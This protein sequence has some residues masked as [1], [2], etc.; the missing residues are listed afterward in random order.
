MSE[1][2]SRTATADISL[3]ARMNTIGPSS[4]PPPVVD[5]TSSRP[6]RSSSRDSGN[7]SRSSSR[8]HSRRSR[9][10]GSRSRGRHRRS[11]H[12]RQ[13]HRSCR[14]YFRHKERNFAAAT[15][16]MIAIVLLCIALVP[17]WIY[18]KGGGCEI[19]HQGSLH[20]LSTTQFFYGGHFYHSH[21]YTKPGDS[22]YHFGSSSNDI[23]VNCVTYTT[24]LLFKAC[25]AFTLIAV[26]CS[27]LSFILNL[28]GPE[29]HLLKVLRRNAIFNILT[30]ALCVSVNLFCY[31][32]TKSVETLQNAS[33][34]H[35][36][37]RVEV[38][39]DASFYLITAA[40]GISVGAVACNCLRRQPF[41]STSREPA[42]PQD[43][44]LY[45]DD[46]EALLSADYSN[47]LSPVTDY[48]PPP[49]Y[50]P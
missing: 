24:V 38:T 43:H 42:R 22:I 17:D 1:Q 4:L 45:D 16:S 14:T 37:S 36:G 9:S 23:M 49:V 18:L 8:G 10:N 2:E 27:L 5:P 3:G 47:N 41:Y 28:I 50:T 26:C 30:V 6:G 15:S 48:P 13:S 20:H 39:F 21:P 35:P 11:S 12:R 19:L 44:F 29:Y 34:L 40:S 46:N 31:W 32:I 7:H 33:R 25:I